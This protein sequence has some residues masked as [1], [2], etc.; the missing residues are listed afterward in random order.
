MD[1]YSLSLKSVSPNDLSLLEGILNCVTDFMPDCE[2][3]LEK[4]AQWTRYVTLASVEKLDQIR[5]LE[6]DIKRS[7]YNLSDRGL[8]RFKDDFD[9][10]QSTTMVSLGTPRIYLEL[11]RSDKCDLSAKEAIALL[12]PHG[13]LSQTAEDVAMRFLIKK[14]DRWIQSAYFCLKHEGCELLAI[15]KCN[16]PEV[17][18]LHS[19]S[20]DDIVNCFWKEYPDAYGAD[21]VFNEAKQSDTVISHRVQLKLGK[22]RIMNADAVGIV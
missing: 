18:K 15:S 22:S 12:F 17:R 13:N 8:L 2:N 3:S 21:A 1:S 11:S 9:A 4:M 19:M 10:S 6:N 5:S 14:A 20:M 16:K 7:I